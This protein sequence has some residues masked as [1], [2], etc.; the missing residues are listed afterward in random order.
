MKEAF[1]ATD[2][3]AALA[4]GAF[5]VTMTIGRLVADR[6][7]AAVGA[8]AVVRYG[9]ILAASG[10][11]V[12]IFSDLI[13]LTIL[14]WAILGLGFS[15]VPPLCWERCSPGFPELVMFP[16]LWLAPDDGGA[17]CMRG[18]RSAAGRG[19]RYPG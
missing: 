9:S 14:G 2:T 11:V 4:Y 13:G 5:A 8:V 17:S 18:G 6:I 16:R 1:Q 3:L 12:V 10:M 15:E 19:S 7:G